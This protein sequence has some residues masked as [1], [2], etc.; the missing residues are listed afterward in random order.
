MK[1]R[2]PKCAP[3]SQRRSASRQ[4]NAN[5][6]QLI[7]SCNQQLQSSKSIEYR[8]RALSAR[9]SRCSSIQRLQELK[10][11]I[12]VRESEVCQAELCCNH[13]KWVL[14]LRPCFLGVTTKRIVSWWPQKVKTES[15]GITLLSIILARFRRVS[16]TTTLIKTDRNQLV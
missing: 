12:A 16:M 6:N 8:A 14:F 2:V 13:L 5:R 3:D 11:P 9:S 15:A 10:R 4:D 1:F 7:V